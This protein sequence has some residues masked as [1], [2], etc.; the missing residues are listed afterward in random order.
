M[1][2]PLEYRRGLTLRVL[3]II[4]VMVPVT[5]IFN[6]LLSGLTAWWVHAGML[7]P[8]VMYI[9]LINELLGRLNPKLKLSRSELA[10]LLTAFFAL[11]GYSYTMYGELKF[12][13]NIVSTYF[14]IMSAV[15]ALSVA[16]ARTFWLDKYP[17][18][19]APPPEVVELAWKGLKPGQYIDWGA[20]ILSITFWTLYFITWSVWSYM[21]AFMLRKQMI[22]VEKLPFAMV[23]PTA[24]PI[25]WSTEP[26]GSPH[27]LFYFKS[28]LAKMFWAAFI[29]GFIGT[30]PDLLV[31]FLPFIPPST[32]WSTHTVNLNAFTRNILPGASFV[33]Y[34]IIPRVAV[35]LLLPL[36][37]LLSGVVAWFIMNVI[38]PWIG[39]ATGILP[40]TPGV[41]NN[42]WN[43][44][45]SVGPIRAI[46]ATNTG[47]I[48]G[49][50]L[51]TLY[52]AWPHIKTIFSSIS[53]KTIEE[54]GV[55]YRFVATTFIALTI[56]FILLFTI[57]G[58]PLVIVLPL[59]LFYLIME[60][61]NIYT[62]GYYPYLNDP[63]H[64]TVP[65]SYYTG[66]GL[67]LWG[68]GI[69]N[70]S[71]VAARTI[72]MSSC[73]NIR[74][75]SYNG[76][77]LC[78]GF[79][80][81]DMARTQARDIL[82]TMII[83][84]VLSGIVAIPGTIWLAHRYGAQNLSLSIGGIS[85]WYVASP[86]PYPLDIFLSHSVGGAA[87]TLLL[88]Y[89]RMRFPGLMINPAGMAFALFSP[90]WY[91]FPNM[92]VALVIKWLILKAG[93]TKIWEEQAV[94]AIIGF[95]CGYGFTY[96]LI[97]WLAF[98]T[99]ALPKI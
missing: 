97:Q 3:A 42:P 85:T 56:L 37:F 48:L 36:D 43:Y 65:F 35:F 16:P 22:E 45:Q 93:G 62:M 39:V 73:L 29:L 82:L 9:I 10:V 33:G 32:E 6:M 90:T 95:T 25:V 94:P 63:M 23:L 54:Q 24:Y 13:I 77:L 71:P 17:P 55:S 4:V 64:F 30:L 19:W 78:G 46:Y 7:P 92:L 88:Y 75:I 11:G 49:I 99:K 14:N 51:Y 52:V 87:I 59:L 44:G 2:E 28:R 20:W 67:G 96:V 58:A 70:P 86:G 8:S 72:G 50:G 34:I 41:E 26:Q 83:V 80:I 31:Y 91:G 1:Q 79:K 47:I 60:M 74:Y 38:Y 18:F 27:N 69:P 68:P 76:R 98:F 57:A 84:A 15:Q 53:G 61:G 5:F 66:L 89:L 12:G 81:G 21:L 40:Y